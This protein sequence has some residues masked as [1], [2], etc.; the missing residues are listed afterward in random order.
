MGP[1]TRVSSPTNQRTSSASPN[2]LQYFDS[3]KPMTIQADA[4]QRGLSAVLIQD[5]GPVEYHSK[6]L[7]ETETRYTIIEREMSAVVHGWEE[8]HYCTYGHHVVVES[9]HKPLEAICKKPLCNAAPRTAL[10]MLRIQTYDVEITYV[11]GKG[12]PLAHALSRLSPCEGETIADVDIQ[13]HELHLH[14][15]ASPARI[16]EIRNETVKDTNPNSW[17]A[18][19]ES[20]MSIASTGLLERQGWT[21]CCRRIDIERSTNHHFQIATARRARTATLWSSRCWKV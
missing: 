10:M 8:F 6:L 1:R 15:N 7:T 12:I 17:L 14:L 3:S 9:D 5:K 4:S 19:Q 16:A 2:S 18:R 11:L 13:V 20:R 21:Y